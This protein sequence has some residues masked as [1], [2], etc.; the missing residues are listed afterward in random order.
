[1]DTKRIPY[2][3]AVKLLETLSKKKGMGTYGTAASYDGHGRYY[4]VGNGIAVTWNTPK[5]NRFAV[6]LNDRYGMDLAGCHYRF[7]INEIESPHPAYKSIEAAREW[8]AKEIGNCRGGREGAAQIAKKLPKII[9][10]GTIAGV[11]KRLRDDYGYEAGSSIRMFISDYV[12]I[13]RGRAERKLIARFAHLIPMDITEPRTRL[14]RI[15]EALETRV[16]LLSIRIL[17]IEGAKSIVR[18]HDGI[19]I[20]K[21]ISP[22]TTRNI[23]RWMERTDARIQHR[24]KMR[25]PG[26]EL[27]G[28]NTKREL[29]TGR[30]SA[31]NGTS[32]GQG[33]SESCRTRMYG[34]HSGHRNNRTGQAVQRPP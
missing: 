16:M 19:Y 11:F 2:A 31:H 26:R 9:V 3:H 12:N 29:Q 13:Q 23:V 4:A 34:R 21:D 5:I 17:L 14:Y 7:V 15:V 6:L 8:I 25:G 32:C 10:P 33:D 28:G 1:M 30:S 18:L 24:R 20:H 22:E 27:C